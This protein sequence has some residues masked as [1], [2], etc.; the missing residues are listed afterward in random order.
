TRANAAFFQSCMQLTGDL[1]NH[2]SVDET[3]G[4]IDR[5]RT[6]IGQ[7]DG[8]VAYGGSLGTIYGTAYL[9]H[10]GDH[11]KALAIDG[12]VDHSVDWPT[13]ISRNDI[14]VQQSFDRFARWCA[15][16]PAC[17][18]H[19][20]DVYAAYDAAVAAQPVVRKLATQFLAAGRD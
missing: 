11:V 18:L 8:L 3:A 12:V 13:I 4:D 14:S 7:T 5:I 6:A 2:L 19:G 15:G 9:E 10:Y 1:M 20:Q 16:E 17:A